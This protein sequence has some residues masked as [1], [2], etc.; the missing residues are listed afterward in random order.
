MNRREFMTSSLAMG[1][2]ASVPAAG[3]D[4]G[5]SGAGETA[6]PSQTTMLNQ[7]RP[8]DRISVGLIGA[9]ARGQELLQSAVKIPGVEIAAVCDAYTGRVQRVRARTSGRASAAEDY[10]QILDNKAID[11]VIIATP[12]HWHKT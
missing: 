6:S 1:L 5:E 3:T 7:T 4:H 8:G 2:G 12:D 9:G 11:A 10:H